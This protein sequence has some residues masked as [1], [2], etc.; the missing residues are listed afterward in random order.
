M[1]GTCDDINI[2]QGLGNVTQESINPSEKQDKGR[3]KARK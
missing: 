1:E 3:K 2:L